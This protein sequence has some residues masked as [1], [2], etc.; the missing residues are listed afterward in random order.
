[1]SELV[2]KAVIDR[3]PDYEVD[4]DGVYQYVRNPSMTG[5]GKLP[6]NL[7]PGSEARLDDHL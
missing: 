4:R 5:L 3:M 7:H 6:V 1:M 2:V